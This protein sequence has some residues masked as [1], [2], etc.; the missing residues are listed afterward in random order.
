MPPSREALP[1]RSTPVDPMT[2]ATAEMF[3]RQR[4]EYRRAW[5]ARGRELNE[6][7]DALAAVVEESAPGMDPVA[8]LKALGAQRDR[9]RYDALTVYGIVYEQLTAGVVDDHE[10]IMRATNELAEAGRRFARAADEGQAS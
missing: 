5:M 9:L 2:T 1:D 4:D 10:R 6:L 3:L 8:D 7:Y